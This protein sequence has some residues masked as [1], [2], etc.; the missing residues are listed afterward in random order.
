[1]VV[2]KL[3]TGELMSRTTTF[4]K[5]FIL[6]SLL[7]IAATSAFAQTEESENIDPPAPKRSDS[8]KP[9]ELQ[10][11]GESSN[12]SNDS[13]AFI[14]G[15]LSF[16]SARTTRDGVSPG[17]AMLFSF[18]PGY[19]INRGSWNRLELSSQIFA[20]KAEF[21]KSDINVGLGVLAKLGF[22]YSLG[23][24]LMSVFRI[25]AGPVMATFKSRENGESVESDGTLMGLGL[26][27][28]WQIVFPMNN[29]L[30]LVGGIALN[31]MQFNVDDVKGSNGATYK[32]DQQVIANTQ[33]VDMGLRIRF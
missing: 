33:M 1:M 11:T 18:E 30:D 6:T 29:S 14:G 23:D 24:K 20:G 16:G 13:G 5:P 12:P 22:G 31:H 19:Q 8:M 2:E 25:G 17:V 7:S 32:L 9:S 3:Q 28:A 21:G 10:M 26:Q 27:G 4:V 15:G